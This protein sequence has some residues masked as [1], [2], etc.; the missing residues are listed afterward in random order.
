MPLL[1]QSNPA[2]RDPMHF[3][4][5]GSSAH[6]ILQ[7]SILEW[8]AVSSSRGSS[9]PRDEL[10]SLASPALE[11][12][13]FTAEPPGKP[14][15]SEGLHKFLAEWSTRIH[16]ICKQGGTDVAAR[17]LRWERRSLQSVSVTCSRSQCHL[18]QIS[19]LLREFQP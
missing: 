13:F 14:R 2:L 17:V 1:T 7:A 12:G 3:S 15:S 9:R 16:R 19:W 4:P 11:G 10:V 5:S 6:G 8:V 18:G